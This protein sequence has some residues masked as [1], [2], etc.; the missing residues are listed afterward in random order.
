MKMPRFGGAF[1][2]FGETNPRSGRRYVLSASFFFANNDLMLSNSS[3]L[4][5][6]FFMG[7]TS[8]L[9]PKL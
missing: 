6:F 9:L 4:A 2:R 7:S 5:P 1:L 3:I 8:V